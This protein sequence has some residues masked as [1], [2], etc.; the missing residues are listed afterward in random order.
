MDT[1]GGLLDAPRARGAFALRAV[2]NSPWCL[3]DI[4]NSPLTLIAG[5]KGKL[6]LVPDEG[7]ALQVGPGDIAIIRRPMHYNLSDAPNSNP[8]MIIHPG[9]RC[10]DL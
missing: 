7:D 1:L 4:A 2:M 10:C 8:Q 5:V 3:R 6:W 9:Q